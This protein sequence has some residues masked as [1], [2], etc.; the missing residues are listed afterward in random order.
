MCRAALE[1][2]AFSFVYE[3]ELLKPNGIQAKVIRAGNDNLL[4]FEI[5]ANTGSHIN[6]AENRNR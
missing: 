4:H 2:I 3:I 1:G 6:R 5:F